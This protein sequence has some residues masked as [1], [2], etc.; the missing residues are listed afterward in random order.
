[1]PP[2]IDQLILKDPAKRH[3]PA[4]NC[5]PGVFDDFGVKTLSN[6]LR[7]SDILRPNGLEEA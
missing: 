6:Q 1:M 4:H 5:I 2:N 7:P 3:T